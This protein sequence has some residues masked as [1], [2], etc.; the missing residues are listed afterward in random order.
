MIPT[1]A[2]VRWR[3][4]GG[5]PYRLWLP[6]FLLWLI[7]LPLLLVLLPIVVLILALAGAKPLRMLFALCGFIAALRGTQ[8]DIDSANGAFAIQ[9]F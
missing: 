6:L 7:L 8:V 2:L 9:I 5:R 4:P 3:R 1:L